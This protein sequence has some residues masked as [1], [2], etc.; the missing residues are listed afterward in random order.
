[1]IKKRLVI[2][3][4]GEFA[5][6]AGFYFMNDSPY[7]VVAFSATADRIAEG[8]KTFMGHPVVPFE[9]IETAYPPD[10]HHM[11]IAVGYKDMNEIR[12]RFYNET[13]AKG[14]TLASYVSS[15]AS[16]MW[17]TKVGDNC[18]VAENSVVQIDSVIGS[19]TIISGGC[20]IA[21]ANRIGDHVF[22]SALV[23]T[24]GHVDIGG[25]GFIGLGS[26]IKENIK[27]APYTLVGA[28]AVILKDTSEWTLHR[29]NAASPHK[30]D[31]KTM[32]FYGV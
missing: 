27:V 20:Y 5:R 25:H 8:N 4:T 15:K 32:G 23:A 7:K 19:N 28:G 16:I 3:G 11:F 29:P 17:E 13:K 12:A 14:Y 26:V 21:H 10:D 2:F 31:R 18:I 30:F 6:L 9:G 1:M 24:G 22:M